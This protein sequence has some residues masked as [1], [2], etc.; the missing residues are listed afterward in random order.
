MLFRT[1]FYI[2]FILSIII[3]KSAFA[4][5]Y[6][7]EYYSRSRPT[8]GAGVYL[9]SQAQLNSAKVS[10]AS[11]ESDAGFQKFSGYALHT[12]AGLEHFRFIQTGVFFNHSQ[13]SDNSNAIHDLRIQEY[14]AETRIVLTSPVVNIGLNGGAFMASAVHT[15]GLERS[16]LSGSGFKGGVDFIYCAASNVNLILTV[17]SYTQ[18][19]KDKSGAASAISVRSNRIGAGLSLWL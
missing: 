6:S 16:Q 7:H 14:G 5:S 12:E 18:S 3:A 2:S 10:G 11:P 15:N 1:A 17:A 4:Y 9:G 13:L 8:Y 19:L